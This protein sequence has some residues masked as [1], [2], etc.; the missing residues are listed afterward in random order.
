V[1]AEAEVVV[2]PIPPL[3]SDLS[4]IP[5]AISLFHR[6]WPVAGLAAAMIVNVVWMGFLG[7]GFFKLVQPAFF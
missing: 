5:E 4:F 1:V 6:I 2:T 7:F 3:T